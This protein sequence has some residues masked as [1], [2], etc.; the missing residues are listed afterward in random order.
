[1]DASGEID[2]DAKICRICEQALAA[3]DLPAEL[4]ARVSSRYAQALVYGGRYERAGEAQQ[5]RA[6]RRRIVG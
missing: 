2:W 6:G 1:M 3:D 5:G 4:R